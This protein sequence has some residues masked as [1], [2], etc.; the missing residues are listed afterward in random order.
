M[1]PHPEEL[2]LSLETVAP[3]PITP[4]KHELEVQVHDCDGQRCPLFGQL[5]VG[6]SM[7]LVA[8]TEH[9]HAPIK[10]CRWWPQVEVPGCVS[11]HTPAVC[12][13]LDVDDGDGTGWTLYD[14]VFVD[15]LINSDSKD[16]YD[17]DRVG[18]AA[19]VHDWNKITRRQ[20]FRKFL[21]SVGCHGE[22]HVMN[23]LKHTV[24]LHYSFL[25]DVF[26]KYSAM[27]TGSSDA[28]TVG[29]SS[30][31][32]FAKTCNIFDESSKLVSRRG[33]EIM[34]ASIKRGADSSAAGAERS[35]KRLVPCMSHTLQCDTHSAL[36]LSEHCYAMNLWKACCA[37]P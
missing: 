6:D 7:V 9:I 2:P 8:T 13:T 27:G 37:L 34:L 22:P 25:F 35:A 31:I 18:C 3:T 23:E 32:L 15:R 26:K 11:S 5:S 14:S 16:F 30:F 19:F 20:R 21:G 28:F 36:T 12:Q 29:L 4:S 1:F 17:D 10:V 24:S 33:V